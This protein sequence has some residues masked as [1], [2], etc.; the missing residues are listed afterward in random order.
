[1]DEPSNPTHPTILKGESELDPVLR[2]PRSSIDI[3]QVLELIQLYDVDSVTFARRFQERLDVR[4]TERR[5]PRRRR[6]S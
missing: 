5:P 6:A 2:S 1:M 4:E 3:V